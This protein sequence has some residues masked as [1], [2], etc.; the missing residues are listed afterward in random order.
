MP[1]AQAL[2][3]FWRKL[4]AAWPPE[5][6][7]RALDLARCASR[8][9]RRCRPILPDDLPEA[10][11]C[12]AS[13]APARRADD[14]LLY[15]GKANNLRERVL[16]HFRAGAGDAQVARARRAGAARRLD[17]NRGRARRA[18]CSRRAKS[19][20][21]S[22]NT[23]GSCAATAS[24]SPGCSTTA[25]R[26]P[27][28]G[29]RCAKCCARG[30]AFGTYRAGTRCAARAREPGARAPLVFQVVRTGERA[31]L[32]F[33]LAGGALQRRLRR[34]GIGARAPGAR[35]ARAHAAAA[36]ALAARGPDVVARGRGRAHAVSRHRRLAASRPP[37]TATTLSAADRARLARELRAR[38]DFDIDELPHP[39][40]ACCASR[41]SCRCPRHPACASTTRGIDS[42]AFRRLEPARLRRPVGARAARRAA[43]PTCASA[44]SAWSSPGR[45][46]WPIA[47]AW[48]RAS[49]AACSS[50]SAQFDAPTDAQL[51]RR[52]ARHR[53][54]C[55]HRSG[56]HAG[57]RL[58]RQTSRDHA[59]ALRRAAPQGRHLRSAARR[60][61]CAGPTSRPSGPAVRVHAHANGPEGHGVH[62]SVGRGPASARLSRAGRRGAAARE[63]RR[64]HPDARR[65]AGEIRRPRRSSSIPCAAR[66]RWSSRPP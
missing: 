57:L 4:R 54:A 25:A 11:A 50:W 55:A 27:A 24:G 18:R 51:L 32:V 31:G 59:H 52:R 43:R 40:A 63:S 23:T 48:N 44:R 1:D 20:N 19:A 6:L 13:S 66:A 26:R 33:R 9:R 30:N 49:A 15:V 39:H 8:C 5:Q 2:L 14:T 34:Q 41:A 16:D 38:R 12:T 61:R 64:R 46:R 7:Q 29:A 21:R 47:P 35:Q 65:L 3:E 58:H 22:R 17:R 60:H 28:R 56:A 37:S 10:R 62:R 42:P 36:Q 53:L 45:W